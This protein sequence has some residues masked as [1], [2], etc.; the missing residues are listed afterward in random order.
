MK[1]FINLRRI[2][3]FVFSMMLSLGIVFAQ[4]RT[5]T[6]KVTSEAGEPMPGVNV[7]VQGTTNG[8]ITDVDGA[9]TLRVPGAE[10]VLVYSSVGSVTQ[11]VTVG[12]QSA[13]DVVLA[14]DVQALQEVVVIGYS[15]QRK[16]DLTGSVGVVEPTKL[17]A[18]P[19]GQVSN[20]LQGRT[21]GVTVL[22]SGQ[23]GQTSKVRIRGFGSF[24]KN[25][26][27]YIVDGVPTQD[28]S[29][30]NP[31]DVAGISVLKDAGA[32]SIYGSR[33]SNGVIIVT[34]KKGSK[35]TKVTYDM[36]IGTQAPG[37]GPTEDLLNTQEY[38][39][40]QWLVYKNDQLDGTVDKDGNGILDFETHPI[41]GRSDAASPTLPD[42]AADTDWYDEITNPAGIQNHDLALSGGTENATFYAGLGYFNQS[43]VII[44]TMS[45]RYSGRFNSEFK[46]LKGRVKV[47]ENL[48]LAYRSNLGVGNL[49]EG[50]PIQMGPYRAQPIVPA[51]ITEPIDGVSHDF[52][53]GEFGGTGIAPRLGNNSNPVANLIRAKDNKYWDVR[54]IG[55][56]FADIK[57]LEGLN[58]R[59][60]IGGVWNNGYGVGYTWA[61]YENSENTAT[62]NLRESA[63]YNAEWVWT[64]TLTFDKTF[65]NHRINAVGGYEAVKYGI[66][67]DMGGAR[68]GYFSDD[69]DFRTL[70][71]GATITDAYSNFYTP[72][73]LASMFLR[74]DYGLMDKYL[75][76]ATVRRDG[77]SVFGPDTRYGVFPSVSLAWR[78]GDEA[79]MSSLAW[80]SDLKIRGSY[81]TMG[82]QLAVS[83]VNQFS[84]YGGSANTSNYDITGTGTSALQ[85]FR[86]VRI[87]N[88]DAK[89]ETNI[90]TNIGFEAELWNNKLGIVF[91]WYTKETEDLLFNP[92]L[93]GTAGAADVP[94]V[95]IA[96]MTNKGV[97]M[98][99]TYKN[100][101][102]DFGL[103]T[104]FVFTSYRNEITKLSDGV[105]FF[106]YGGGTSRIGAAH[107]NQ[108]GEPISSFYGYNVIGLFQSEEEV[109]NAPRQDG[110]EPGF[111]RYENILT[112]EEE[113]DTI[114]N[115]DDRTF[116]GSPLPDF[117][118]GLNIQ[119]TYKN[120][121]LS[122]FFFGAQG[123]DIF[124][125][126]RW[127]I[128]FWP[129]F[130]G[131]K[132]QAALYD[133]WTPDR[134]GGDVPKASSKSNFSTNTVVN[135][136]YME[137]GSYLRLKNLQLGYTLPEK[138]LAKIN[139]TSLRFY[140]QAVNL[141]TVT[142]YSGLDPELGGDDR[143]YGSDTGNYPNVKQFI[144]G[145]NLVL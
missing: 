35:G 108:V 140:F 66:G 55:N 131:Q 74:A 107:R 22:G 58:Y 43:G 49:E 78:I 79:F 132:S 128:D 70:T 21:S 112:G 126:N 114:I 118:Y 2:A 24:E 57:I 100:N 88:P 34:T 3:L 92:E 69:P 44:H 127:W 9:Y 4:E 96:S 31:N 26:P 60:T 10:A 39:D 62:P 136:Y 125:W 38:A 103:N 73:T 94:Y 29:S 65:G 119:L 14:E 145:L 110:A 41:Y 6:G 84:L 25:D 19:T 102:G 115:P 117:T 48:T 139:V 59:S 95:N 133:S 1:I 82:N 5:V 23:P 42:W 28:I 20:Q 83:A 106:D 138:T 121:D 54:I 135:S 105:D 71:N 87:G 141:F 77:S 17:T 123:N 63:Y 33:A 75:L 50:S 52:V 81:G 56:L 120:F 101:W 51:F 134:T 76:S 68:A 113:N 129:S 109:D 7:V 111:F 18:I 15:S 46:F 64:N 80:L 67:R 97:D 137:D 53:P 85:G 61:T 91:D 13:I 89:W 144:F 32:A 37:K 93:P 16:R 130:Q 124:N 11:A 99:L 72:V 116:L 8:T 143:A 36:F 27:L 86:P 90:T 122:A 40:L 104:S 45:Q 12:A 47:G 98:E 30:L 142:K